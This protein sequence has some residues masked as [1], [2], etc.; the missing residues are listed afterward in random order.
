MPRRPDSLSVQ[1]RDRAPYRAL[2]CE[3]L[4]Q[5]ARDKRRGRRL[6]ARD[7]AGAR[8]FARHLDLPGLPAH[9]R[10]A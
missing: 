9:L 1:V 7:W 10:S 5:L 6:T 8:R 2:C 4:I 3:L